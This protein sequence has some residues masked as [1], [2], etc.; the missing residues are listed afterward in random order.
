MNI[1][2]TPENE[3]RLRKAALDLTMTVEEFILD[4]IET[5]LQRNERNRLFNPTNP[6]E[7]AETRRRMP[8]ARRGF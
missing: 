8:I 7:L 6:A 3:M 4:A 1:Q 2:V 5:A